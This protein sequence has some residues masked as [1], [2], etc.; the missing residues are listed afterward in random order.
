[1]INETDAHVYNLGSTEFDS[2]VAN[3][4]VV[5]RLLTHPYHDVLH[6]VH[7][8]WPSVPYYRHRRLHAFLRLSDAD[9]RHRYMR[10]HRVLQDPVCAG[11]DSAV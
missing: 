10:R 4:G 5:A 8:T 7:H 2:S 11:A 9:Y 1:M 6:H 3:E